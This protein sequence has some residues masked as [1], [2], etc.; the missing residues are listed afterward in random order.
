MILSSD[1][2]LIIVGITISILLGCHGTPQAETEIDWGLASLDSLWAAGHRDSAL[3]L[4]LTNLETVQN[5]ADIATKITFLTRVGTWHK[6]LGTPAEG[7]TY[8]RQALDLAAASKDS[9][10]ACAP[11]RG[12]GVVLHAL[13]RNEEA[14]AQYARLENLAQVVGDVEHEGWAN[15]GLGYGDGL[16]YDN[17]ASLKHYQRAVVLFKQ[18]KDEEAELWATL[19]T[20]NAR[21]HLAEYEAAGAAFA[22]VVDVAQ[23]AGFSRH[24]AIALNNTAGLRFALG[25]P[26][27]SLKYYE[28][29]VALWDSIGQDLERLPPSLN[30]GSCLAL[31]GRE[32]EARNIFEQELALCR[33]KKYQNFEARALRKLAKLDAGSGDFILAEKRYTEILELGDDL[34]LIEMI[35]STLGLASMLAAQGQHEEALTTLLKCE[36]NM[37]EDSTSQSRAHL[38]LALT[39]IWLGLK[40]PEKAVEYLNHARKILGAAWG[41]EGLEMEKLRAEYFFATGRRDSARAHLEIAAEIW[42][43]ERGL[44]L[45][46]DWREERG[47][48]GRTIFCSLALELAAEDGI[49]AAFEQMQAFKGRVLRERRFGPGRKS[50]EAV[51]AKAPDITLQQFQTSTLMQNELFLDTY[52]GQNTS[53]VF[54]VTRNECRLLQLPGDVELKSYLTRLHHLVAQVNSNPDSLR[55]ATSEMSELLFG[56]MS[57][58]L[59]SCNHLILAADGIFNLTPTSMLL[60][61]DMEIEFSRVPS[62]AILIDIRQNRS[63]PEHLTKVRTLAVGSTPDMGSSNLPGAHREIQYLDNNYKGVTVIQPNGTGDLPELE[64]LSSFDIIHVAAHSVGDDRNAWQSAILLHPTN[65]DLMIRAS[66]LTDLQLNTSLVVLA[67]CSS[68]TGRILSGEGVQGL[69][70]AFLSTGV[71]TVVAALWPVDDD[72]T[73]FFMTAFYEGLS[74]G[75]DASG[76]LSM[77]RTRCQNDPVFNLPFHWAAFV[78]V[79][80]SHLHLPLELKPAINVGRIIAAILGSLVAVAVVLG[81]TRRKKGS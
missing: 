19:G 38:D 11:R 73:E 62:A 20:A 29:A 28:R 34:P 58:L 71:P 5:E 81:R 37:G 14:Y 77:A 55:L 69:A 76:A 23:R 51:A 78:L 41:P 44:P 16:K 2:I 35:E 42:E 10:L 45:D 12:L 25:R 30:R 8:H 3:T 24:E 47:S 32:N 21:F 66:D 9:S 27:L 1:K 60:A 39:R 18:C 26:D 36:S 68:A 52:V 63:S 57:D 49:A 13:G 17:V 31:L 56:Q 6:A 54:A 64:L 48:S 59:E 80:D 46:P 79:G 50:E 7:E 43:K 4:L 15:I 75:Y 40:Q 72:A 67:S 70:S 65:P 74:S 53:L 33:E 61:P 22:E